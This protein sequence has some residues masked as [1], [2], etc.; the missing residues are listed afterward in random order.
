VPASRLVGTAFRHVYAPKRFNAQARTRV[1]AAA[2]L[3]QKEIRKRSGEFKEKNL[4]IYIPKNQVILFHR[5]FFIEDTM[6]KFILWGM[7]VIGAVSLALMGFQCSSAEMTSA[8][9]YIQRKEY[10]GAE[11]QLQKELNKNPNN[12]EAWYLLGKAVYF[13]LNDYK[14]MKEVFLKALEI[15]PTHKK[16]IEL[17][18]YE[19]WGRIFNYG[20]ERINHIVD[21]TGKVDSSKI[22]G[23]IEAFKLATFIMPDSMINHENLGFAYYRKGDYDS[24]IA[25]LSAALEKRSSI[26]AARILKDIYMSKANEYKTKFTEQNQALLDEAKNVEQIKEKIKASDVKYYLGQPS[27]VNQEKKGSGKKAVVGKE[28]WM[29]DKYNLVVTVEKDMVTKV[30]FTKPYA[31]AIDS[32]DFKLAVAEFEKAIE[33]LKKGMQLDPAD[34]DFSETLMN[35]YI[36]AEKNE[37]AR[38]LLSDRVQRFP[39]SKFDRYNLG[40]FLLKENKFEGAVNEF[41]AV[42]SIDPAFSQATYNL[43]AAYVNW[44]VAEQE[45]LTKEGKEADKSYQEKYRLAVPYLEKVIETEENN[46]PILELLGKVYA[47]LGQSDKAKTAY[48]KADKIRQGRN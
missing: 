4:Y 20:V 1:F 43:A 35:A 33:V 23:A 29:Y 6:K 2:Y 26:L 18:T 7:L 30:K 28:E 38:Q 9:L 45:R 14:K 11:A 12:E 36:G 22:D 5:I 32:T 16:E 21:S 40:V 8:K 47:N 46:V 37:E 24:A 31:P 10:E 41:K 15:A 25:P 17:T 13:E 48:E 42:L 19:A 34:A 39:D 44:G 27:S 3:L